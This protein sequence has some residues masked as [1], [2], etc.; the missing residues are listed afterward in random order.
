MP[1]PIA[2]SPYVV[3]GTPHCTAVKT[4]I[5]TRWPPTLKTLVVITTLCLLESESEERLED[6]NRYLAIRVL[7]MHNFEFVCMFHTNR[8]TTPAPTSLVSTLKVRYVG[9]Y[10]RLFSL[11]NVWIFDKSFCSEVMA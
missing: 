10:L 9:V 1:V 3:E 7:H 4:G 6:G 8:S 2:R 5:T 11:F